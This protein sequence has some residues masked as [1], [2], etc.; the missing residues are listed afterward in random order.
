METGAGQYQEAHWVGLTSGVNCYVYYYLK[1]NRT[2]FSTVQM[3]KEQQFY[4]LRMF[5]VWPSEEGGLNGPAPGG[6]G[7]GQSH[8]SSELL[9]LSETKI[10]KK[11]QVPYRHLK[12]LAANLFLPSL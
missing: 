3:L 10:W 2:H 6:L 1:Q 12:F 7:R 9:G 8:C 4:L 5:R 11:L